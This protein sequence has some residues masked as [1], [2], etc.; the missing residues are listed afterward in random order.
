MTGLDF[1]CWIYY[2][3]NIHYQYFVLVFIHDTGIV[4][5]DILMLNY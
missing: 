3:V 1:I 2:G 5:V 4:L